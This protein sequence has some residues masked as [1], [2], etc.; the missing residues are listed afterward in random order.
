MARG[1]RALQPPRGVLG[2]NRRGIRRRAACGPRGNASGGFV[3]GSGAVFVRGASSLRFPSS[4]RGEREARRISSRIAFDAAS[5]SRVALVRVEP[6]A[7]P[8]GDQT[9]TRLF[10]CAKPARFASNASRRAAPRR[11]AS[12][13]RISYVSSASS[14]AGVGFGHVRLRVDAAASC[15]RVRFAGPG[16]SGCPP[17]VGRGLSP[18]ARRAFAPSARG[19]AVAQRLA[20]VLRRS[21]AAQHVAAFGGHPSCGSGAPGRSRAG[22]LEF[23]SCKASNSAPLSG[24]PTVPPSSAPLGAPTARAP[25]ARRGSCRP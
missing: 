3:F 22:A 8:P 16:V 24:A 14:R 25:C 6:P 21:A 15:R 10:T 13:H 5:A 19:V 17:D 4:P 12:F 2:E 23:G 11:R 1:E 7:S 18:Q 20:R 9:R